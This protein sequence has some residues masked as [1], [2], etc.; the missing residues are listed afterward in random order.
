MYLVFSLQPVG[1]ELVFPGLFPATVGLYQ[2]G[3]T[4]GTGEAEPPHKH[5]VLGLPVLT[6]ILEDWSVCSVTVAPLLRSG[7]FSLCCIAANI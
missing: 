3:E 4:E 7:C 1:C 5:L 2:A 6:D